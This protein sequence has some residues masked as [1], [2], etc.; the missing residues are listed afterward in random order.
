MVFG[1]FLVVYNVVLVKKYMG[2]FL[3][4][5]ESALGWAGWIP[6]A[7]L[8]V[9]KISHTM[10]LRDVEILT[11]Q[12]PGVN[13][14]LNVVAMGAVGV[15]SYAAEIWKCLLFPAVYVTLLTA[16]EALVVFGFGYLSGGGISIEVY[17]LASNMVISLLVIGIWRHAARL[18]IQRGTVK[19]GNHLLVMPF[20]CISLYYILFEAAASAGIHDRKMLKGLIAAAILVIAALLSVY[21]L[22]ARLAKEYQIL[23]SNQVYLKQM[24]AYRMYFSAREKADDE[25]IK[26]RHDLKQQLI[27][28][29]NQLIHKEYEEME[30]LIDSMIG[31]AFSLARTKYDTGNLALEA[32][33]N[34][35]EAVAK[36]KGIVVYVD[37][38][39]PGKM[40]FNDEDMSILL[41]NA[42]D[43]AVEALERAE[44]GNKRI[45]VSVRYCKGMLQ[46][47]FKNDCAD[48][49]EGRKRISSKPGKYHG[50]GLLS[51]SRI[52]RKYKGSMKAGV[53]DGLFCLEITLY[54]DLT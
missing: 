18:E 41:G 52:V 31:R 5:R 27:L 26:M 48:S 28:M 6:F 3:E 49:G 45:W 53:K 2:I 40:K 44:G 24:R 4:P 8:E 34:E 19:R 33:L 47:R 7:V 38:D 39:V 12:N 29:R 16:S 20:I 1:V 13:L 36:E 35:L 42:I 23:K 25:L 15:F 50:I 14:V 37:I 32:Q 22:Y 46:I 43:N 21:S 30:K 11:G 10:E 54:E 51:I 9:V 17:F